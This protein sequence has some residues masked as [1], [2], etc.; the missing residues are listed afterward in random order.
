VVT[1]CQHN[2]FEITHVVLQ[3][4][5]TLLGTPLRLGEFLNALL[6]T[7]LGCYQVC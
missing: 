7:L 5:A 3:S 6:G 2:A 1:L 4:T